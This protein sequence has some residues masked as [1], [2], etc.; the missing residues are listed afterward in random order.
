MHDGL[1]DWVVEQV[2]AIPG[3]TVR[4]DEYELLTWHPL[5]EGDL[6]RAGELRHGN[7]EIPDAGAVPYSLP[8]TGSGPLVHLSRD[9]DDLR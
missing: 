4:T 3:F 8:T 1:I 7:A 9:A 2:D 5:P 6:A